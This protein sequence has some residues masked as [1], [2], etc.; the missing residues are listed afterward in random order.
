MYLC[1]Y[2]EMLQTAFAYFYEFE[3]GHQVFLCC[4]SGSE[5]VKLVGLSQPQVLSRNKAPSPAPGR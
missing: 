3:V 1:T 4:G 2:T 5:P